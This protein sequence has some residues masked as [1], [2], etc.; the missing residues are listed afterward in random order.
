MIQI[1]G[2]NSKSCHSD[3]DC[4]TRGEGKLEFHSIYTYASCQLE[5]KIKVSDQHYMII[6]HTVIEKYYLIQTAKKSVGCIPW[7]LPQSPSED[8][9]ICDPWTTKEFLN[10]IQGGYSF[11]LQFVVCCLKCS[12]FHSLWMEAPVTVNLIAT[13]QSI[14]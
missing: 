10:K 14:L 5:C 9:V 1:L 11:D 4:Y 13:L 2:I 8:N 6:L 7:Y 12:L 3:R